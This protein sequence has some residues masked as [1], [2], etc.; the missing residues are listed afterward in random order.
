MVHNNENELEE[1]E[2]MVFWKEV[3]LIPDIATVFRAG[4]NFDR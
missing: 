1:R 3:S 4:H 2:V